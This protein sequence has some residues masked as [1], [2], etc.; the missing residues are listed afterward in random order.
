MTHA[1]RMPM[2]STPLPAALP[3]L[4]TVAEAT[5]LDVHR[6]RLRANDLVS[7]YWGVR[8]RQDSPPS[9]TDQIR[10]LQRLSPGSIATH[11]TAAAL[12]GMWLPGTL[13]PRT[14][15]VHLSRHRN[16]GGTPRR[17]G[18]TGHELKSTAGIT[19]IDGVR[20]TT[21]AHTWVDLAGQTRFLD[22]VVAC[23]DSLLQRADG[24]G[25]ERS[26]F[27]FPLAEPSDVL[28]AMADRRG[29]RGI[30]LAQE[31]WELV[32]SGV[33]SIPETRVRLM[34]LDHGFPEPT[35]NPV[36]RLRDGRLVRP[37]LAWEKLK[38]CIQYDGDYHRSQEQFRKDIERDRRMQ[39]EGWIVI[40][41]AG[42]ALTKDGRLALMADL[43]A[44]FASR[45]A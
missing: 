14:S 36:V 3:S 37:D 35:V 28:Q 24:P 33:D 27:D 21:P 13:E 4:F 26:R 19:E 16:D 30:R 11:W 15:D 23:G 8:F 31:A 20:L 32:R 45:G 43:A 25:A 41:V 22:D 6:N 2:P 10:L 39:A 5:S 1:G 38:I 17:I 44:A 29:R 18:V 34:T 40:R 12:W 7:P 9:Y 42:S